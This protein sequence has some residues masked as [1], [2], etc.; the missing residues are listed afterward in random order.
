VQFLTDN[1]NDIMSNRLIHDYGLALLLV[2][3]TVAL[4]FLV[5]RLMPHASLSLL[6][7]TGVLVVS[8]RTGLGPSLFAS[9][10][11]FLAFNFFFTQPF[12]TLRVDDDRD[13]TTLLFFL[14]IAMLTGNLAARMN[15]EIA[16]RK[17]SL[18]KISKLHEFSR[19]MSS[20]GSTE[21]VLNELAGHISRSLDASVCVIHQPGPIKT[22]SAAGAVDPLLTVNGLLA[23]A[24]PDCDL[25]DSQSICSQLQTNPGMRRFE[26]WNVF[27]LQTGRK[28]INLVLVR[29]PRLDEEQVLEV[30]NLCD[31]ATVALDRTQ[32]VTELEKERIISETEQLRSALLSSVSHDLR[33]PL[34]S[35]IGSTSSLLELRDSLSADDRWELLAMID[36]EAR[37][38]DRHVQNLLDMTRLGHGRLTLKRDWVD[39]HDIVASATGRLADRLGKERL[40]IRIPADFPLLWLHGA[41]IEQ[42]FFN[43]LDNAI[44]FSPDL[45]RIAIHAQLE[46]AYAVIRIC[47]EGPGVPA[48]EREKIFDMFYTATQGD[49]S[50]RQ[51][52]GLGLAICRGMVAAHG[53]SVSA[54]DGLNGQG[55][56]MRI[57]LP[58]NPMENS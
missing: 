52:T 4:A 16:E 7:L 22:A 43:L 53:G 28:S 11:S 18:Q 58:V 56:C 9:L 3:L 15:R 46:N 1:R 36:E 47:D 26:N 13:V 14:L 42:A 27:Q 17:D 34:A 20:A 21:M 55:T 38:L 5:Q 45:G 33:T 12:L 31:Q 24:G 40:D 25:P 44:R 23:R 8:S 41:L 54:E 30:Q 51:G 32:L 6:F 49:R 39:L 37:R 19:L 50:Q 57:V 10:L 2:S 48:A 29:G 35:I